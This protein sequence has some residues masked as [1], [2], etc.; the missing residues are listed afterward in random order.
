MK[1][2]HIEERIA[3][4]ASLTGEPLHV[5]A[6]LTGVGSDFRIVHIGHGD[7]GLVDR[8]TAH[9]GI[10]ALRG[11]DILRRMAMEPRFHLAVGVDRLFVGDEE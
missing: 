5:V 9:D 8:H 6:E 7:V 2:N 1:P 11:V 3:V 10:V 4:L